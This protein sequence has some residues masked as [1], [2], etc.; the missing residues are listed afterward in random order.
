MIKWKKMG[1]SEFMTIWDLIH[2]KR[3]LSAYGG[4]KKFG[5]LG[6]ENWLIIWTKRNIDLYLA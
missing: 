1:N 6:W 2:N 4:E 3:S 5:R